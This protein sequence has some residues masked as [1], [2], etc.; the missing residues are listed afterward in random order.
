M[1]GGQKSVTNEINS[2]DV[3]SVLLRAHQIKCNVY[4][5][6]NIRILHHTVEHTHTHIFNESAVIRKQ[7][8]LNKTKGCVL[9]HVWLILFTFLIFYPADKRMGR[10][11]C[12]VNKKEKKESTQTTSKWKTNILSINMNNTCY[13]L[14]GV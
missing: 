8:V 3:Q 7:A 12:H 5:T 4:F 14:I 11:W 2:T 6:V 9:A 10:E 1:Y 13:G